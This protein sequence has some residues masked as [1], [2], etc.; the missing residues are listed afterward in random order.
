MRGTSTLRRGLTVGLALLAG[1]MS[2]PASAQ[3]TAELTGVYE[4]KGGELAVIQASNESFVYYS[5][6]FPQGE[7]VGLCECLLG[8][9]EKKSPTEWKLRG[10]D[11][12]ADW[13]LRI[14]SKK[15]TLQGDGSGCCGAG[16]PGA[17]SFARKSPKTP[18]LCKVKA[19]RA[20]FHALDEAN[21]QRKAFVV[22]G[23]TVE[24]YLPATEPALVP[25]RFKGPKKTTAGLL[26]LEDL[27][28]QEQASTPTKG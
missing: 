17:D 12:P 10:T 26:K 2:P 9:R 23:D 28:C 1:A 27:D 22:E 14:E 16:W 8:L 11:S 21:T 24:V 4:T 19:K 18:Q 6:S 5:S 7:S 3:P 20:Y 13:T 25:A 15:L